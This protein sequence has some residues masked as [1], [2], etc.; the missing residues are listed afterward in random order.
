MP[1]PIVAI[2]GRPNVGKSS[3]FNRLIK[4]RLAVV[5]SVS[6]IT[7]DRN[8]APCDWNGRE[9]YLIDTGGMV[10][11]SD[12]HME[13]LILEQAQI[14]MEEADIILFMVDSQ[15][16]ITDIDSHIARQ[17]LKTDKPVLLV[18]NKA[19]NQRFA[20]EASV[21]YSLGFEQLFCVSAANGIGTG[22]LLD[23]IVRILPDE[24]VEEEAGAYVRIAVVGRP[25]VGK[26]SFVN[27]LLGE[28]RHIVSDKPGTT[29]DSIDSLVNIN[30]KTYTLIDT[31][32]L[33]KKSRIKENLEYYTTLRSIRAIQRCDIAVIL[34][35][36]NEGLNFQE[37]KIIDEVAEQHKGMVLAVNKWDIFEKDED[38][39]AVYTRQLKEA[40]PSF[41]YIPTIFI[42]AKNGKRVRKT[43]DVVDM[44]FGEYTK[45]LDTA[46]LNKWLEEVVKRQPPA[47]IKGKWIK[48][49]Y[50]TQPDTAPPKLLIFSNYPQYLQES[51]KRYLLNRLREQFGFMGVPVNLK[52]KKRSDK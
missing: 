30:G 20:L 3:L 2:V 49:Y 51:Y 25:N 4:Q 28:E 31:A 6:G 33:R 45:R 35:D 48:F 47:A 9:F 16:G 7:R 43:L 10:P 17:L 15:T 34:L 39:V 29:R 1:L 44:V 5:D 32:G 36:A 21:F 46:A 41:S 37:L 40:M 26:S 27:S 38:S 24:M 18:P 12:D 14:G 42:S 52:F 23:E 19:D 50:I 13:Q 22:D 11:G 8:F